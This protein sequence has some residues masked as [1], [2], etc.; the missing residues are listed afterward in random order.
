MLLC[1]PASS[2]DSSS[3]ETLNVKSSPDVS[4]V[5]DPEPALPDG[6]RS[7]EAVIVDA[8][9]SVGANEHFD[10]VVE[11]R[12][13]SMEAIDLSPCPWFHAVFGESGTNSDAV[14]QLPCD[15]SGRSHRVGEAVS[16]SP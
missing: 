3:I 12:N 11:L 5:P 15:T 1:L 13:R 14:G 10:F 2:S 7:L 6:A 16:V 9:A 8:P 4:H